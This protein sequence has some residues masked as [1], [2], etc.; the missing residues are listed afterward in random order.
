M[1]IL[2]ILIG[3]ALA[4]AVGF[5]WLFGWAVRTGQYDDTEGPAMRMLHD[6]AS[7]RS[8]AKPKADD[9]SPAN[10]ERPA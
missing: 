5:L 4:V 1:D 6:D 9:E 10:D 2:Y 3:V 7:A 8:K